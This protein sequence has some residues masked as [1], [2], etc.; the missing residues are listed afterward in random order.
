MSQELLPVTGTAAKAA[1]RYAI[2]V[3]GI[4][5]LKLMENASAHVAE[6]VAREYPSARVL[7]ACGVG[8][9]GADGLCVARMLKEGGFDPVAVCCGDLWKATWEFLFQLSACRRA[10][11]RILRAEDLPGSLPEADV[12]VDAVFGIG[13]K[14]EVS[15]SFRDLLALVRGCRCPVV[16]VDVPSGINADTGEEMGLSVRADVTFT[17]GRNKTG[18]LAGAGKEAAGRVVVCDIGIPEEAYRQ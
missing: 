5:S 1:D 7:I 2:D 8:N 16:S 12:I 9:N 15:G 6:Y 4:P 17:F 11:V 18:L 10:G 14:R 3:L 13:L